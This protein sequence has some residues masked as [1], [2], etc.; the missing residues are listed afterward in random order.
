[1]TESLIEITV[2]GK[3]RQV[4]HGLT[5]AELLSELGLGDRRVAVECNRRVIPRA[6]HERAELHDGDRLELVSFVG[7][8]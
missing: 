5:V 7:G 2:N 6:E 4:N 3:V 1:M 8:G